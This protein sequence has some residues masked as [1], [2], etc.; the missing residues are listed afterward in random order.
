MRGAVVKWRTSVDLLVHRSRT[1]GAVSLLS[2]LSTGL[3]PLPAESYRHYRDQTSAEAVPAPTDITSVI[4][5]DCDGG[6]PQRFP[7]VNGGNA[8]RRC[9]MGHPPKDLE[10]GLPR[11]ECRGPTLPAICFLLPSPTS[12]LALCVGEPGQSLDARV[13]PATRGYRGRRSSEPQELNDLC[14]DW[15]RRSSPSS[16]WDG[17]FIGRSGEAISDLE[18]PVIHVGD[19]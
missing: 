19:R 9:P 18:E 11:K 3:I 16:A 7:S 4:R 5:A 14:L 1:F 10:A 6:A 15:P 8:I 17:G 13:S 2:V 12:G